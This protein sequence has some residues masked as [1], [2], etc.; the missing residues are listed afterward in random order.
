[1]CP[2]F[3]LGSVPFARSEKVHFPVFSQL[4]GILQELPAG[5]DL[6]HHVTSFAELFESLE[7]ITHPSSGLMWLELQFSDVALRNYDYQMIRVPFGTV[8]GISV[9]WL[10][11]D[12]SIL[13]DV[14]QELIHEFNRRVD[15]IVGPED[16]FWL[17]PPSGAM[18]N[19]VIAW[20]TVHFSDPLG[21][22]HSA[23]S[24]WEAVRNLIE[25]ALCA[26]IFDFREPDPKYV[27]LQPTVIRSARYSDQVVLRQAI[28]RWWS[29]C[30]C[31]LGG[32]LVP[33]QSSLTPILGCA[34]DMRR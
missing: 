15:M 22:G 1:M 27:Y 24:I 25:D 11:I 21:G 7:C 31:D 23:Y 6:N 10:H 34:P 4:L 16:S 20:T 32:F 17:P 28:S 33:E 26:F 9:D 30:I 12:P 5:S 8:D 2:T 3:P 19:R 29:R 14:S 18:C 13:R